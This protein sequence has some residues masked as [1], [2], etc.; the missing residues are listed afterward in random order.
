MKQFP[1]VGIVGAGLAVP[2]LRLTNEELALRVNTSDEW[3]RSRTGISSRHILS[4]GTDTSDLATLAGQRALDH[5]GLPPEAVD[6]VIVATVSADMPFPNAANQVQYKLGLRRGP[7]FDLSA[8]CS[9]YIYALVTGSMMIQSGRAETV[10]VVGADALSKML[11]WEDRTTCV[12]FG[13]GAGATVLRPVEEGY[14][15]LGANLGSDGAGGELL[16]VAPRPTELNGRS[17]IQMAGREVFK[18]AVRIQ[19]EACE[20]ALAEAGITAEQ[21]D[22][23]IPHQANTRIIEA[24]AKGLGIPMERV[25][26]N[27]DKY[28]NTSA[29]S[30]PIAL[31][32]AIGAGTF[33]RGDHLLLVGFGAGLT[34]GAAVLRWQ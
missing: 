26:V 21:V 24:A 27:V 32:E 1:A 23:L 29:A 20:A 8:A 5:A 10:L 15:L 30:I 34:W 22:W 28:G 25:Y 12:L 6:A 16:K 17:Y 9:G 18:F 19:A 13:D 3:I 14:G 7:A 11:D 4:N 33:K 31:A 2:E